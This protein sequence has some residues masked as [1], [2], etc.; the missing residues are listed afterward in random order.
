MGFIGVYYLYE[1]VNAFLQ[2]GID[3]QRGIVA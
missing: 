2:K 1:D 3:G